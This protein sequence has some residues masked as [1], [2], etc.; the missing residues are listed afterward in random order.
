MLET[1]V[2][3]SLAQHT[4]DQGLGAGSGHRR[5]SA[6]RRAILV[7]GKVC[8]AP[9]RRAQCTDF[10]N[11]SG[12]A[13][14]SHVEQQGLGLAKMVE[15]SDAEPVL[16][17]LST[18]CF[19][20]A[21]M[22]VARP[23][24]PLARA[25]K[26]LSDTAKALAKKGNVM[27]TPVLN[28]VQNLF[29]RRL[30]RALGDDNSHASIM[31][32]AEVMTPA[33]PMPQQNAATLQHHWHQWSAVTLSG[34][35]H[36]VD[37]SRAL[38]SQLQSADVVT[39]VWTYDNLH[40]NKCVSGIEHRRLMALRSMSDDSSACHKLTWMAIA[41]VSHSGVLPLRHIIDSED[42]FA[43]KLVRMGHLLESHLTARLLEEEMKKEFDNNFAYRFVVRLPPDAA[44]WHRYAART[45]ELAR[46][47]LDMSEAQERELLEAANG[48]WQA[49]K[50]THWCW[51]ECP[52]ECRGRPRHAQA[53]CWLRVKAS[54][55][56]FPSA[57]LLY[58]WKGFEV[59]VCWL[60]RGRRLNDF[61]TRAFQRVFTEKRVVEA[62]N[63]LNE[64]PDEAGGPRVQRARRTNY[65]SFFSPL[66][67]PTF[68]QRLRPPTPSPKESYTR[69][70]WMGM[71]VAVVE[72]RWV[73]ESGR[74]E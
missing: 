53:M 56:S 70:L 74:K 46:P 24:D 64:L 30:R 73:C 10:A 58:R 60:L 13:A 42:K 4:V 37:P 63:F 22:W 16:S 20:D 36:K 29:V 43:S 2:R 7:G 19:D 52:L 18:S 15:A 57:P 67:G 27:H 59:F 55:C 35:G 34:S 26:T 6:R 9:R 1:V 68:F 3:P 17:V 11:A 31:R 45:L 61:I 72:A 69:Q 44:N 71:G 40:T 39:L 66:I 65:M 62:E 8:M 32:G 12:R 33:Q 23:T 28:I 47:A 51:P 5:N 14:I 54:L 48:D 38:D 50:F 49:D 41:C 25:D 21:S